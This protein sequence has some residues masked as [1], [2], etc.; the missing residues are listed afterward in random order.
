ML[1]APSRKFKTI[2]YP[3]CPSEVAVINT[4]QMLFKEGNKD[5]AHFKMNFQFIWVSR[6]T[7]L[8]L[9]SHFLF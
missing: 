3:S 2:Q 1:K 5:T 7:Q 6:I 9:K 8:L 4:F